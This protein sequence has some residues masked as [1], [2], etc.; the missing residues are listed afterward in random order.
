MSNM[1]DFNRAMRDLNTGASNVRKLFKNTEGAIDNAGGVVGAVKG[2]DGTV[3]REE[4]GREAGGDKAKTKAIRARAEREA[5]ERAYFPAGEGPDGG[6]GAGAGN[7]ITTQRGT[8]GRALE[9]QQRA[10][11]LDLT[12]EEKM[13][14]TLASAMRAIPDVAVKDVPEL[15]KEGLE[16]FPP[17][18][19]VTLSRPVLI[20]TETKGG[21]VI[22]TVLPAGTYTAE[23]LVRDVINKQGGGIEDDKAAALNAAMEAWKAERAAAPKV[24]PKKDDKKAEAPKAEAAPALTEDQKLA[25]RMATTVARINGGLPDPA[26]A[27]EIDALAQAMKANPKITLAEDMTVV[28]TTDTQGKPR[29]TMVIPQGDHP[30]KDVLEMIIKKQAGDLKPEVRTALDA[31]L[32]KHGVVAA[33]AGQTTG[34]PATD[35]P[36]PKP[37]VVAAPAGQTTGAAAAGAAVSTE[38]P[39][40][41]GKAFALS[42]GADGKTIG[43]DEKFPKLSQNQIKALQE[44]VGAKPDGLYG[45]ET[46][47]KTKIM[48]A[49][50]GIKI[51][52]LNLVTPNDVNT[53]KFAAA[54]KGGQATQVAAAPA[55]AAKTEEKVVRIEHEAPAK[56]QVA[57]RSVE[58]RLAAPEVPP[59]TQQQV[60]ATLNPQVSIAAAPKGTVFAQAVGTLGYG[61]GKAAPAAAAPAPKQN[62]VTVAKQFAE[63]LA[64]IAEG[65]PGAVQA[66][67]KL[68]VAQGD[69][70]V[71]T[72]GSDGIFHVG[73]PRDMVVKDSA[74]R[75][76]TQRKAPHSVI[77][78]KDGTITAQEFASE[79]K[80]SKEFN[81]KIKAAQ[82]EIDQAIAAERGKVA[83]R[84]T[85]SPVVPTQTTASVDFN[86]L[87]Q[88][89]AVPNLKAGQGQSTG[90][91]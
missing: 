57:P 9:V 90:L 80:G 65:K 58:V 60:A 20:N 13:V 66:Y 84:E 69:K 4:G 1:G 5:T 91:A 32:Q 45:P 63:G 89:L 59:V 33:A 68:V 7:V 67:A 86:N 6:W 36:A 31:S 44:M 42:R 47:E 24:E 43:Q 40:A 28:L 71:L 25:D 48:C 62:D 15:L 38:I 46:H 22:N 11:I 72:S 85:T 78:D 3:D 21:K 61:D 26:R 64:A 53:Q 14:R 54:V 39:A 77:I 73:T 12:P 74:G 50:A 16:G 8:G 30:S 17:K 75:E 49:K 29:D 10:A 19:T 56:V 88:N 2:F 37:E 76:S 18:A 79:A 87:P 23:T 51:E 55:P 35:A 82:A 52:D 27:G 70:P 83:A 81:A 34:A 41:N